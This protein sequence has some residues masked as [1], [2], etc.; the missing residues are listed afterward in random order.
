MLRD[1]E[2][3]SKVHFRAKILIFFIFFP[4]RFSTLNLTASEFLIVWDI[5]N[6]KITKKLIQI[7]IKG[8]ETKL[9]FHL[10]HFIFFK[11]VSWAFFHSDFD[12]EWVSYG[13]GHG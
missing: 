7:N 4:R 1:G 5:L 8:G 2:M 13:L 11:F 10:L 3:T 6:M 12:G 9:D